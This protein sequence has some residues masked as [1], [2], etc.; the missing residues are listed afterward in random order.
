MSLRMWRKGGPEVSIEGKR[1][2]FDIA[3]GTDSEAQKLDVWLPEGE[4]P[5]PAIISIHGGGYLAGD[6]RRSEMIMPMLSGLKKGYAVIGLN[7][8]LTGEVKFP[9]PVKD[10]K[11]GIR[12]IKAHADEWGID[13]EK[14]ITWGG[15]AG[16]YMTLMSC[17]IADVEEFD[18]PEDPNLNINASVAG[19]IGWYSQT[20]F[21]T[22]DRDLKINS[23]I[24]KYCRK[25]IVDVSDEYEPIFGMMEEDQFPYHDSERSAE[26]R[27][28]GTCGQ[29]EIGYQASPINRIHKDIPPILL[30]HGSGDEILPMQQS[31]QFAL[32]ANEICGEERVKIEIIP[33]AIHSSILFET[34]ENLEKC[35]NFIENEILKNK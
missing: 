33:N 5:F 23:I 28:L 30:Q 10:V 29:S 8:R 22:C 21:A 25:E 17:L 6:K 9:Y 14:L 15:S 26:Y 11:Q 34:E 3:Y 2:F 32:K 18:N 35:L 24:N 12:F 4:G 13:P 16:G 20:D 19:G 1:G 27:F 7:Y 31:I